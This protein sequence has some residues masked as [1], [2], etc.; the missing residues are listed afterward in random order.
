[1]ISET[2]KALAFL[3]LS[4]LALPVWAGSRQVATT[5]AIDIGHSPAKGG[6]L[7]ARGK[8]EYSFN[9]EVALA[10]ERELA[11]VPQLSAGILNLDQELPLEGR[12]PAA[13]RRKTDILVSIHHDS[14][15]EQFLQPWV[16]EGKHLRYCDK[17]SGFSL[18][19]SGRGRFAAENRALAAAI[20]DRLRQAGFH[21]T[22]HHAQDIPGER[23]ILLDPARGIYRRD[24]LAVLKSNSMVAVLLECGVIMNREEEASL[25]RPEVQRKIAQAVGEALQ[26]YL[27]S[28]GSSRVIP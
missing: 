11:K 25:T 8:S 16:H 10:L 22:W 3:L 14:V 20:G 17:F 23:H 21:P 24:G 1:M 2:I 9:R 26:D 5:V 19:V 7:S 6:A 15:Q 4:C 27:G 28:R 13:H 18:F 12:V